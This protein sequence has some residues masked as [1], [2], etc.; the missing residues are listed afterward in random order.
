MGSRN[1]KDDVPDHPARGLK[2]GESEEFM[3]SIYKR[4]NIIGFSIN[5]NSERIFYLMC[6]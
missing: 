3:G 2:Q 4:G 1:R 5:G 6:F